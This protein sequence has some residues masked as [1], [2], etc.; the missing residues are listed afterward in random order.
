MKG[1]W[2]VGE[3]RYK[4]SENQKIYHVDY[5]ARLLQLFCIVILSS[6]FFLPFFFFQKG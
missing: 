5:I 1:W 4:G 3:E 2:G 6:F